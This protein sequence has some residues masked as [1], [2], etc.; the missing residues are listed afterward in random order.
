MQIA[1]HLPTI[2]QLIS[3][4]AT[5]SVVASTGSGKS[6]GIPAAIASLNARCFVVVPTRTAA[7]SLMEYQRVLQKSTNPNLD[8]NKL[9]GYAA[10]GQV[11]YSNETL[12]AYVTGGHM[13][14]KLLSYFNNG[15]ASPIDFCDVL[16]VDEVHVR[17]VD[18]DVTIDLW[19]AAARQQVTVPRLVIASATPSPMSIFPT[20]VEY[21]VQ[22]ESYPIDF[23]YYPTNID[24]DD[25][26]GKLYQ[27]TAKYVTK[28]HKETPIDSGHILV[29]GPGSAEVETMVSSLKQSIN[30]GTA[31][32]IPAFSA[33]KQEDIALIYKDTR[34]TVRKIVVATNIAEM[35]LTIDGI[36]HVVD[37]MTEK[38]AE[39]A[40][41][42][43]FRLSLHYIS[44][45]S[46]TQRAGR[47]GRTRPGIC[48]RMCTLEKYNSLED[49]RPPE[50]DRVPIYNLVM[51][52]LDVGLP[53]E[54]ILI[55]VNQQRIIDAL[56]L[57]A[58]LEMVVNIN[59]A[60]AVTDSG[61][62]APNFPLSVRN[63]AFLWK[64]LQS[65]YPVFPG[66]VVACLIDCY[67]PS[68]FWIPRRNPTQSVSDYN[69]A[70]KEHKEKYF[71]K[72][73]GYNDLETSIN[74]WSDLTTTF[75]GIRPKQKEFSNWAR[76]NSLNAKKL[77]EL[78]QI[79]E[80]SINAIK[81]LGIEVEIGP[82]TTEGA[83]TAARPLLRSVYA[84]VT[85]IQKRDTTYFNPINKYEYR[86]DNRDAVNQFSDNPPIGVI[87]LV[88]AE[89]KSAR[90]TFRV[91][92]FAVDTDTDGLGRPIIIRTRP[93]AVGPRVIT[94]EK[95]QEQPPD[96]NILDALSLLESLNLG[97]SVD[98]VVQP[99]PIT[100]EEIIIPS[101]DASNYNPPLVIEQV[102]YNDKTFNLVQDSYLP[103]GTKQRGL[104]YFLA[105][106]DAGYER[107]VTT[108]TPYGYGQVA[109]AWCCAIAG[110]G[111]D[112]FLLKVTPRTTMTE[113]AIGLGAQVYEIGD[114]TY[115]K[116][117]VIENL[118]RDHANN[119]NSNG[120][121][122]MFVK[123]GLDDDIYIQYLA[124]AIQQAAGDIIPHVIWLA[125]GSGVIARALALAFPG[126][127][128]NIVQVGRKI[129]DD[130]L[131]GINHTIYEASESFTQD[132]SV[133]PPY[134]S[135]RNYDA[136]VW[137]YASQYGN[138]GDFIWNVK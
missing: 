5:V 63:A 65:G 110:L 45:A 113:M 15:V 35:A 30:D 93:R 121:N 23:T 86:L 66:I 79:V 44:K 40:P 115:V 28:L 17:D 34:N 37:T 39:T 53:P 124:A 58:K 61:H 54:T 9:V 74:L 75:Q 90:G 107:V 138:T 71:S 130:V 84:D 1:P 26:S 101:L 2:A 24:I 73:I 41:S 100:T 8:V 82:F 69:S 6:I 83:T 120:I 13:R 96:S 51:E 19:M 128:L 32:I 3:S 67:G 99:L 129:Y 118:A 22:L 132:A 109:A 94:R 104:G 89:I 103:V 98:E 117:S 122:T 16:M 33:L 50:I 81:R 20:P 112:L 46:A 131:Q 134:D 4:N 72:Y 52:L 57:L 116:T 10:E 60:I 59:G 77:K 87:A 114:G 55:G 29:F 102:N 127:H 97:T 119:N 88:S 78:L 92:S 21:N 42:G 76:T 38:R 106:K 111:F 47:T 105:I 7:I 68:Y 126:V 56:Q 85:L 48:H 11:N 91:V 25:P 49:H 137:K 136:K 125:G 31:D 36:G 135:L 12:I 14:R 18:S 62:F 43:G 70:V 27:E 108:A 80:Q 95:Q 133:I 123:L 64:W